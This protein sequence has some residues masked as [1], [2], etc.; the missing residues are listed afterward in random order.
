MGRRP[1]VQRGAG[2]TDDAHRE[3][4]RALRTNLLAAL[5]GTA[6]PV[7]ALTGPRGREGTTSCAIELAR[8]V[9][10]AGMR[11]ILVDT[12][13]AR[14]DVHRRLGVTDA[15]GLAD[16]LIDRTVLEGALQPVRAEDGERPSLRVLT[17]GVER[18]RASELLGGDR[19]VELFAALASDCDLVVVDA[20][21]VLVSADALAVGRSATGA[22]LV[23]ASRKTTADSAR[24][25]HHALARSQ[26]RVLGVVVNDPAGRA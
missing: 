23:V 21:P 15:V 5:W 2:P 19:A 25:A 16:V 17:A 4:V 24:E 1:A 11:V 8:A 14:P 22:V 6:H 20:A 7:V 9:G 18:E 3:A 26:T 13:F 10:Q 12:H